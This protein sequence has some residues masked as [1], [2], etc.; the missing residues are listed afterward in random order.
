MNYQ[1]YV[2]KRSKDFVSPTTPEEHLLH[3]LYLIRCGIN[4]A[5]GEKRRAQQSLSE[6]E[7]KLIGLERQ[8]REYVDCIKAMGITP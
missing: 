8:E 3:G 2:E 7:Q 5:S 4:E 6:A 1:Q